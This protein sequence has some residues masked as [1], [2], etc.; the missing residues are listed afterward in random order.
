MKKKL[1]RYDI[2]ELLLDEIRGF[3]GEEFVRFLKKKFPKLKCLVVGYDFCFGKNRACDCYDL[4]KFF[5]GSVEIV[6]EILYNG[7]S[8]HAQKIQEILKET[9]DIKFV[10]TLLGRI[11]QV[12]GKIIKGQGIGK[13]M[14]YPTLNLD[15]QG[16]VLPKSGVYA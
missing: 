6:P 14:L 10:N 5:E 12:E 3:S 13:K 16:Y 8:V 1:I 7:F 2:F 9:G 15:V 11:Y 4:Q